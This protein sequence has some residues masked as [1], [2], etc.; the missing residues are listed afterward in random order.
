MKVLVC[1]LQV[2]ICVMPLL[3]CLTY[4]R[5]FHSTTK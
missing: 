4:T 2:K 1:E 5:R 3:S